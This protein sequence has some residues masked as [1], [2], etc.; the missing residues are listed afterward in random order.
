MVVPDRNAGTI[1]GMSET[2]D[3]PVSRNGSGPT[4]PGSGAVGKPTAGGGA[5]GGGGL[6]ENVWVRRIAT[7]AVLLLAAG[8]LAYG[9]SVGQS[10]DDATD[11]V[12]LEQ[13]PAPGGRALRQTEVG[14]QLE[15]GYDGRLVVNGIAIPEEQME[16]AVNPAVVSAEDI[17]RYGVRPNNRDRVVFRP[18][19]GKVIE[20]F[21][22]GEVQITLRYFPDGRQEDSRTTSW[23]VTVT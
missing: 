17:A 20:E 2:V 7:A 14:A 16:G 22:Q 21:E 18:G 9:C 19:P 4:S 11:S 1:Q 23:T 6:R 13:Y 8:I 15:F 5:G 12:I 10:A 3:R